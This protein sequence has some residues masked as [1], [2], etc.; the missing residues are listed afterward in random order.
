MNLALNTARSFRSS[1]SLFLRSLSVALSLC[2]CLSPPPSP[3]TKQRC[4]RHEDEVDKSDEE[5]KKAYLTC[6]KHLPQFIPNPELSPSQQQ[7]Q[8]QALSKATKRVSWASE[9]VSSVSEYE[10]ELELE[11]ILS[12]MTQKPVLRG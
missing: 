2:F 8:L 7:L 6:T 12:K 3:T 5:P 1:V 10:Y 9:R 11:L 4:G